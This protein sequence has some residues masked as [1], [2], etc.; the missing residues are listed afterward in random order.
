[1]DLIACAIIIFYFLFFIFYFLF[2]FFYFFI[3]FI[4]VKGACAKIL[5]HNIHIC[6]KRKVYLSRSVTH[7]I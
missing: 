7:K 5:I 6:R 1:M 3:F 2:L 4:F